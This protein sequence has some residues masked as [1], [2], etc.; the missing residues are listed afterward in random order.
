M[1]DILSDKS[2]VFTKNVFSISAPYIDL[3]SAGFSFG[4]ANLW[5]RKFIDLSEIRGGDSV[6]DVCTGT[7][8]LIPLI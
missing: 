4:I 5:R 3:L 8:N 2:D 6:L 1:K 7:G